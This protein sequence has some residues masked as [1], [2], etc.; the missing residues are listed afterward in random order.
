V[1]S[2]ILVIGGN[3][4]EINFSK[5]N[6]CGNIIQYV[7]HAGPQVVCCGKTMERLM[8]GT[9]DASLEKHVPHVIRDGEVM[10]VEVGSVIHPMTTEHYIAF[11]YVQTDKGGQM[12]CLTLGDEP[13]ANFTFKD[14]NPIA[15]Y[16]YCNLHG[17]WKTDV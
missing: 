3:M 8:P 16:E 2:D 9:M 17:L 15:V 13:V 5:C 10:K 12:R 7:V 14:E 4:K 11:I 6:V 1:I